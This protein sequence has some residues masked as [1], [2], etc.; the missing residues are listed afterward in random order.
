[1]RT[2]RPSS[3]AD[4]SLGE[5]ADRCCSQALPVAS[6][7]VHR[8]RIALVAQPEAG[9]HI[10]SPACCHVG[11][12]ECPRF[13][14]CGAQSDHTLCEAAQPGMPHRLLALGRPWTAVGTMSAA[15][16]APA[17]RRS[18]RCQFVCKLQRKPP[19]CI[20][21]LFPRSLPWSWASSAPASADRWLGGWAC[22]PLECGPGACRPRASNR[23]GLGDIPFCRSFDGGQGLNST[24]AYARS[25][26]RRFP[27][28]RS[29]GHRVRVGS[30]GMGA[31]KMFDNCIHGW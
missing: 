3:G 26:S 21:L 29:G 2:C 4:S 11:P 5:A 22:D 27:R 15:R 16:V 6:S 17:R 19:D 30:A 13:G 12:P 1:M 7:V 8:L 10:G 18:R 9:I 28:I 14:R 24:A 23:H 31:G 25:A 20:R